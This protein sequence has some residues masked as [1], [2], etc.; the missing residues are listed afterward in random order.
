MND[1]TPATFELDLCLEVPSEEI[2]CVEISFWKDQLNVW[3]MILRSRVW[4]PYPEQFRL[5]SVLSLSLHFVDD[6]AMAR[7]N[8]AWRQQDTATDV[9]SF[10]VLGNGGIPLPTGKVIELGDIIVS[11]PT[12]VRQAA[13]QGHDLQQELRWLVSHGLLHLLG[14]EHPDEDSLAAM[15]RCQKYL[16]VSSDN[17]QTLSSSV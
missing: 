8:Q 16:L 15:L 13:N 7:L 4:L 9:L 6:A 3:L 12:A 11:V 5:A 1:I 2:D 14:W 17:T 10:P